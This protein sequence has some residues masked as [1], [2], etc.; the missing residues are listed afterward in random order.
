[1]MSRVFQGGAAKNH[2]AFAIWYPD[3]K[4]YVKEDMMS[5]LI[6]LLLSSIFI[7]CLI[8]LLI[9]RVTRPKKADLWSRNKSHNR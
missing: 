9:E 7:G 4:S 5:N 8:L 1:M 6:F 2:N 3:A